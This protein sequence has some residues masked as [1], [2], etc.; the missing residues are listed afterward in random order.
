VY[1]FSARFGCAWT[2]VVE[3]ANADCLRRLSGLWLSVRDEVDTRYSVIIT[4]GDCFS[5]SVSVLACCFRL[6]LSLC[7]S[8]VSS[9]FDELM[10]RLVQD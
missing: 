9:R 10:L 3:H 5:R 6:C 8:W 4:L 2:V 7:L 1:N